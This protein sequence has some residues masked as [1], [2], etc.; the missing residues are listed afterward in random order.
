MWRS[1]KLHERATCSD[2]GMQTEEAIHMGAEREQRMDKWNW[3]NEWKEIPKIMIFKV[4]SF[5]WHCGVV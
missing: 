4:N 1:N 5:Q 2:F 3:K